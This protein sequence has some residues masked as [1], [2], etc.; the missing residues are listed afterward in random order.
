[1]TRGQGLQQ[2]CHNY[3]P[4]EAGIVD[5]QGPRSL[6]VLTAGRYLS[7]SSEDRDGAE[8]C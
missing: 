2:Q 3:W 5:G 8:L 6:V 1:M 4:Q 7:L